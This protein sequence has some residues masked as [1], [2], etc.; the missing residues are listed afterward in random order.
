MNTHQIET[1][2][3]TMEV[4]FT[5]LVKEFKSKALQSLDKG[6]EVKL[7]GENPVMVLLAQAPANQEVNVKIEWKDGRD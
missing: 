6:F 7:Q 1:H 4:N 3:E 2:I 5:A